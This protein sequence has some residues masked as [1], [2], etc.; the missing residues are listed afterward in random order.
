MSRY[1]WVILGVMSLTMVAASTSAGVIRPSSEASAIATLVT[2]PEVAR[3]GPEAAGN[4]RLVLSPAL[5]EGSWT[6][7]TRRPLFSLD[8][9]RTLMTDRAT[10]PGSGEALALARPDLPKDPLLG[11]SSERII[12][13][14]SGAEVEPGHNLRIPEPASV[15]LVAAGLLGLVA[16]NRMRRKLQA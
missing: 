11:A 8:L 15:A 12:A 4:S 13:S 10:P 1:R 6:D 5:I 7:L 9:A 16:R 3:S 2:A 14:E